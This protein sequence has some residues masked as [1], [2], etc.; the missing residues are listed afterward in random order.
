MRRS[1]VVPALL[2]LSLVACDAP[3]PAEATRPAE[4]PKTDA[5]EPGAAKP[6]GEA[7]KRDMAALLARHASDL[8]QSRAIAQAYAEGTLDDRLAVGEML[9]VDA[10]A[11]AGTDQVQFFVLKGTLPSTPSKASELRAAT[12]TDGAGARAILHGGE[13]S[14]RPGLFQG[15]LPGTYT[16]CAVVGPPVSAEQEAYRARIEAAY[17]AEAGDKLD[18]EKLQAVAAKLEAETGYEPTTIDWDARPLRC[19]QAEVT[20]AADSRVVVLAPG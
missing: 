19:K 12:G 9:L 20:A 14:V 6:A 15:V 7:R 1:P 13:D 4:A 2:V 10:K 18:P 17:K 16:V 11:P 5:A 8:K 3:A